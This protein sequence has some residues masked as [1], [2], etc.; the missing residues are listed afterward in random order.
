MAKRIIRDAYGV[1]FELGGRT[2]KS[3]QEATARNKPSKAL[4]RS[5]R[6]KEKKKQQ[7]EDAGNDRSRR[8]SS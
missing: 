4:L 6:K 3:V 7:E 5:E 1:P 8:H 2:R